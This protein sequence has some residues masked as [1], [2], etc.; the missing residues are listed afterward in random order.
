MDVSA[1]ISYGIPWL[2]LLP[3]GSFQTLVNTASLK[4][5]FQKEDLLCRSNWAEI[6]GKAEVTSPENATQKKHSQVVALIASFL[7]EHSRLSSNS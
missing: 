7:P 2:L 1:C 5:V 6:L 3:K 4:D